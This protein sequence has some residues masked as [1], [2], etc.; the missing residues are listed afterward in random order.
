MTGQ[1]FDLVQSVTMQ[2]EGIGQTVSSQ[3]KLF[4][5][6]QNGKCVISMRHAVITLLGGY[7]ANNYKCDTWGITL[8]CFL[9]ES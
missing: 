7:G 3:L 1:G 9:A 5:A 2:V 8:I 4:R 6:E